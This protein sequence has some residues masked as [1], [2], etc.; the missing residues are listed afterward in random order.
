MFF[1]KL[2]IYELFREELC[3][4]VFFVNDLVFC[5]WSILVGEFFV[6]SSVIF[7]V[8][9]EISIVFLIFFIVI[10]I[11]CDFVNVGIYIFFKLL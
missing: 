10:Y 9:L 7:Y 2:V 4:F 6:D 1:L 3:K 8:R 11:Y 5:V